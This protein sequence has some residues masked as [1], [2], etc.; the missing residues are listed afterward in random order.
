V[1]QVGMASRA[2]TIWNPAWSDLPLIKEIAIAGVE[3]VRTSVAGIIFKEQTVTLDMHVAPIG[4]SILD[5]TAQF[6]SAPLEK[7]VGDGLISAGCM[8]RRTNSIWYVNRSETFGDALFVR[9]IRSF[10]PSAA[11]DDLVGAIP[12][13][14][15]SVFDMLGMKIP[16]YA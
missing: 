10:P 11:V 14:Q 5:I 8:L 15:Q 3:A 2:L 7:F 13:D 6:I 9:I 12:Q 1:F 4:R 16:E